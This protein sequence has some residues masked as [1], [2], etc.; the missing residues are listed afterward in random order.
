MMRATVA[1]LALAMPAAL[2]AQAAAPAPARAAAIEVLKA[3]NFDATLQRE[4]AQAIELSRSAAV[5]SRQIDS[6]P[7]MRMQRSK[8]PKA[9][10]AALKRI[11]AKEAREVEAVLQELVPQYRERMIASY[12]GRFSVDEL[13]KL[14]AFYQSPLGVKVATVMPQIA[15]DNAQWFQRQRLE[16]LAPRMKALRPELEGEIKA[17][18]PKPAAKK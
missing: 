5:L 16:K 8:N 17:L 4:M 9:W 3:I 6:N 13:R 1:A 15:Q 10:D 2:H 12:A 14:A 11:G 7:A 18:L